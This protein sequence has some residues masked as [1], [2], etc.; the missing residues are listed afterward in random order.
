MHL[1]GKRIQH[2]FSISSFFSMEGVAWATHKYIM[3]GFMAFAYDH[4]KKE[5]YGFFEKNDYFFLI[6]ATIML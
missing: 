2:I 4:H 1:D 3:H 6:F 5:V